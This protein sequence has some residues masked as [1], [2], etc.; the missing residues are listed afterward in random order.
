[1]TLTL[2]LVLCSSPVHP[3]PSTRIAVLNMLPLLEAD[4]VRAELLHAPAVPC[5]TPALDGV[6]EA[7]LATGCQVVLFQKV[8]GAHAVALAQRLRACGIATVF[9]VC[10]R[11]DAEMAAATDLTV[12]VTDYLRSQ[13]PPEL[14]DKVQ[15]V[16]DGIERPQAHKDYGQPHRGTRFAPLRAVLVTSASLDH[17]PVLERLPPW[18]TVR[19]VGHYPPWRERWP[20]L[21]KQWTQ[22]SLHERLRWLRFLT[23][24]SIECV[25]WGPDRVYEQLALGDIGIIPLTPGDSRWGPEHH[26]A[27]LR[28]SENRLTLNMSMGLPVIATPIPAYECVIEQGVNGFL[29][30]SQADWK[31]SFDTLRDPDLRRAMG[32]A[33]RASVAQRFSMQSQAAGLLAVLN[34]A[35]ALKTGAPA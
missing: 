28:K 19:I 13:Y 14:Q 31:H 34:R 15:V 6:A 27:W 9:V 12:V 32:A 35:R 25:P 3:M 29:A 21:R 18:L 8:R 20:Q 2:G 1:M 33:A 22:Q 24:A 26:Q 10:D 5:E 4:G 7:A 11:I 23:S 17:L 16:H 30:R